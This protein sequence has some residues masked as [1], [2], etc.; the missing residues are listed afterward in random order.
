MVTLRVKTSCTVLLSM[1]MDYWER[2]S[3][4]KRDDLSREKLVTNEA[5]TFTAPSG[6]GH[7]SQ[8]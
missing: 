5:Q 6:V 4:S 7:W 1:S 2:K 8:S 3:H